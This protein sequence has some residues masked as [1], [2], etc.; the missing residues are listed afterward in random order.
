MNLSKLFGSKCRAKI[1]EKFVLEQKMSKENSGFF[2]REL[3]RSINEQ[4]NSVRRELMN[5]ENLKLLKS[6]E[7]NKK[8]FYFLNRNSSIFNEIME[9][10][11]KNYDPT[12]ELK[13]F[14]KGRKKIE[15]IAVS[16]GLSI[17]DNKTNN[18][19]DIFVI[20]DLDKIEFNNFL[21]R[22]F[23]GK[24]IKYAVISEDDFIYRLSYNDK[25][26]LN[27]LKQKGNVF[28]KDNLKI[29][30]KIKF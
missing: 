13:K 17:I 19:V 24:K 22:T 9:I 30:E 5:L 14:F 15:L 20:G 6:K 28:L 7:E 26:V 25:L 2:I 23:F 16:E 11:S 8:K 10:F 29:Q 21:S 4:I 1:L 3:C 18:I 12:E 27:I